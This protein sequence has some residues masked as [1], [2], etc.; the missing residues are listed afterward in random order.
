MME[1]D[2]TPAEITEKIKNM[3]WSFSRVSA[4]SCM[5]NFYLTYVE[6]D[7]GIENAY[8][9][10][11]TICHKAIEKLLKNELSLFNIADWYEENYTNYVT[12]DFPP[13]KYTDLGQDRY[14]KGLSYFQNLMFDFNKYEVL[15]VEKEYHFNVGKYP[16]KGFVDAIYRDKETGEIIIRD[17]KTSS[18]KYKKDGSLSKTSLPT[19]EHYKM[20]ELIY[21]IPVMEEYGRV[22]YLSWNMICD[23]HEIKIP[24]KKEEMEE[25]VQWA[26]QSIEKLEQEVLW[27]PDNSN[28]YFCS[29]LCNHRGICPYKR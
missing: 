13:N 2:R 21:S 4:D 6:G 17:H 3:E 26:I 12:C 1:Y 5:Y 16:F 25:T 8:A 24:Y 23:Q 22:D 15:G 29:V 20:Q 9:Q 11:G 10:F 7:K 28:S 27:L 19:F 18:F 14:E